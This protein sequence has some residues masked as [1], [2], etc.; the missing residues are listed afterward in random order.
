MILKKSKRSLTPLKPRQR[1][2]ISSLFS[3]VRKT[4]PRRCDLTG[5]TEK[6]HTPY[7]AP[8][9]NQHKDFNNPKKYPLEIDH[10]NMQK[11]TNKSWNLRWL[12]KLAHI[13]TTNF[14]LFP[15]RRKKIRRAPTRKPGRYASWE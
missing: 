13:E 7:P 14:H 10:I 12:T 9:M 4:R 5:E 15:F 11:W 6:Y 8:W 3:K 2:S 1:S